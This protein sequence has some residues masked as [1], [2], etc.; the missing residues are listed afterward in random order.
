MIDTLEGEDGAKEVLDDMENMKVVTP[1]KPIKAII[2]THFHIDHSNGI[3]YF[4][5]MFPK[6]KV[7]ITFI[8]VTK[9]LTILLPIT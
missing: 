5:K 8:F 9:F 6:A 7:R 1:E 3:G 2:I 4:R